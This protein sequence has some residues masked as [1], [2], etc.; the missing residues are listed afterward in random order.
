[1]PRVIRP[2]SHYKEAKN[3]ETT[4]YTN[5]L[6]RYS[7]AHGQEISQSLIQDLMDNILSAMERIRA[8]LP[9]G[10]EMRDAWEHFATGYTQHHVQAERYR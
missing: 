5:Y 10:T 6:S 1:M 2:I 4:N 9:N 3:G 7:R 8:L